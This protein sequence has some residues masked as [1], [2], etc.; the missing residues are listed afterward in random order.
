MA[1]KTSPAL[2]SLSPSF[3]RHCARMSASAP[4]V[5]MSSLC[6]TTVKNIPPLP[7]LLGLIA[8]RSQDVE[9]FAGCIL[10]IILP[11]AL[12]VFGSVSAVGAGRGGAR[13]SQRGGPCR[14]SFLHCLVLLATAD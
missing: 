13:I 11:D 4:S 12:Q 9:R 10:G 14:M 7:Q 3:S 6:A 5:S 1:E 8:N 2:G